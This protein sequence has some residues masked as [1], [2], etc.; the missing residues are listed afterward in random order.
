MAVGLHMRTVVSAFGLNALLPLLLHLLGRGVVDVGFA[1]REQ[2]LCHFHDDWKMV[3]CVGELVRMNLEH[4][5][6][7]QNHLRRRTDM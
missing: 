7:F 3:T 5:D 4:G 2:L 1:L 6:V